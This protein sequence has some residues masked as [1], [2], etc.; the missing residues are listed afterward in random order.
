M[1]QPILCFDRLSIVLL[2]LENGPLCFLG[3][4]KVAIVH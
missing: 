3:E 1:G 4:E 2:A